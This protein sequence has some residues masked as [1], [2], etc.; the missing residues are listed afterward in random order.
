MICK[1]QYFR[2]TIVFDEHI[3]NAFKIVDIKI[4]TFKTNNSCSYEQGIQYRYTEKPTY[5][6]NFCGI[7]TGIYLKNTGIFGIAT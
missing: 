2:N 6:P 7:I 5:E 4:E 1:I 3:C